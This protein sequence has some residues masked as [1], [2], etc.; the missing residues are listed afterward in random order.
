VG[1]RRAHLAAGLHGIRKIAHI[2]A[3]SSV[4]LSEPVGHRDQPEFWN[5]VTRIRTDLAPAALLRAVKTIEAEV[6]RTPT[7][8]NG[9]REIDIDLLLYDDLVLEGDPTVPHPRMAGRAFVLT[10]LVELDA[11]ARDPGTGQRYADHLQ[12]GGL[13]RVERLFAGTE[14]LPEAAP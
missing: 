7:F 10:P 5:L 3:V 6:G 4:Y 8:P 11:E 1:E 9:P 12:A 2:E 13:E 14:L